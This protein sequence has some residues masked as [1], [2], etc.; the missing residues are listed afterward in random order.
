MDNMYIADRIKLITELQ[1][2]EDQ[3]WLYT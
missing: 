1:N 3:C 2:T